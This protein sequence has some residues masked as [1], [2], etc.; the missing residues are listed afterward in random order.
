MGRMKALLLMLLAV[1]VVAVLTTGTLAAYN[2]TIDQSG[3]IHAA[4]MVFK[5]NDSGE[6]TQPLGNLELRPGENKPFDIEINTEGSEV[7]LD[8]LLKMALSGSELPLGLSINVD[9]TGGDTVA[10]AMKGTSRMVPV[11]VSWNATPEEL[12]KLYEG[13]RNFML[14]LSATVTATQADHQ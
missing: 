6:A 7:A 8:V 10:Y 11:V 1:L 5:V 2:R 12:M 9:N 14:E 4:K 3:S 13:S